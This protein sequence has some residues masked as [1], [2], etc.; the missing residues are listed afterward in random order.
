MREPFFCLYF[1]WSPFAVFFFFSWHL[2]KSFH[3]KPTAILLC[4]LFDVAVM[5]PL[6]LPVRRVPSKVDRETPSTPGI[7]PV[8]NETASNRVDM[9]DFC[10][11]AS[12]PHAILA[13]WDTACLPDD[14]LVRKAI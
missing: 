8:P 13:V 11:L 7:V 1:I 14:A 2:R 5:P 9:R 4:S 6:F 12:S 3:Q 10:A